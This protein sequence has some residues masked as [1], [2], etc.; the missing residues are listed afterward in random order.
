LYIFIICANLSAK[1]ANKNAI[2]SKN[3]CTFGEKFMYRR[4]EKQREFVEFNLPFGGKLL[5]SNRWVKM[6]QLIPWHEFEDEYCSNLSNSGQGPPAFSVRMAL[7]ALII[8]ERLGLSD[9]ECVE[10]IHENPYLQYF[11]GIK[12]FT[13]ETPFHPTMYVHFR[14]RFPVDVINRINEVV[15]QRAAKITRKNNDKDSDKGSGKRSGNGADT[16]PAKMNKGKLLMDATCVPADITFP[17]DLK[18]LNA[19]REKTEQIIDVLHKSRGKGHKKPRTYRIKARKA[20]LAIAKSKKIRKTKLRKAIRSQLGYIKRNLRSIEKLA[21]T[22]P[23]TVLSKK[24]YRDLLVISELYRQQQWMY[25]HR[26]KRVDDR[27]VSISQPH[28]R[29]IKRGKAGSDTEF[30]AKVSVSLVDGYGF[31]DRTSWDNF[32]ESGDLKEQVEAYKR[33]FGFYPESVHVD[34]IYRTRG[35]LRYCKARGIRISGPRLGRPPT[36]TP[37]NVD[38]LKAKARRA[39][40]DEI[41]RIPIEGKF[42]QGKRKYGIGRLMT[43][44]SETSET[45]IS[46]CFLV[47]NLERWLAAIFLRLFF[48]EQK[49][50]FEL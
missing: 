47:M 19:A 5:A 4:T 7:A 48:K 9:E 17:T 40:Q 37:E 14:K 1:D 3:P 6:S 50:V 20:W 41:D 15:V 45:A 12:E 26:S 10:Q 8:K 24:Q 18:L 2:L 46:L 22:V 27:I 31:V 28:V 11:C 30:G 49:L 44:L 38:R 39:R 35:N 21:K 33:R 13:T 43:K 23:L 25:D 36:V 29:P 34:K 42:G 16:K 32:N